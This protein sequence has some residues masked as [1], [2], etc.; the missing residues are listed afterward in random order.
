[1]ST[2]YLHFDP[3]LEWL[4]SYPVDAVPLLAESYVVEMRG[5][6]IDLKAT[7][8][9]PASLINYLHKVKGSLGMIGYHVLHEKA[10]KLLVILREQHDVPST[11]LESLITELDGSIQALEQWCFGSDEVS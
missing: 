8:N 4:L 6:V 2:H 9:N 3:R 11:E 1:M 10:D 7:S 5:D